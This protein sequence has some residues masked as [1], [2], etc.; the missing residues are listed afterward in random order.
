MEWLWWTLGIVGGLLT[1]VV[2]AGSVLL[3]I[4]GRKKARVMQLGEHT[5]GWLVQAHK[6]IFEAG[7]LDE[8]AVVVVSPDRQTA[9]DKSFMLSMA[10]RVY[11]L[12]GTDPD[13]HDDEAEA[14][15]AA[16]MADEAYIEG[17]KD[18]LPANFTEGREVWLVHIM[19]YRDDLPGKKLSGRRVPCAVVWG[20]DK[21]PVV[22]RP[23]TADEYRPGGDA[24]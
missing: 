4:E 21:L 9:N 24:Y 22:S 12:K 2:L 10:E 18:R 5:T 1:L 3:T 16:L 23:L 19:I 8:A 11:D 6:N 20:D 13:E 7:V 14:F 17:K 15:V